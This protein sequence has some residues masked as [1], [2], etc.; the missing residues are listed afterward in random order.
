MEIDILEIRLDIWAIWH[1][2]GEF[3]NVPGKLVEVF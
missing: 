2:R 1:A 3:A